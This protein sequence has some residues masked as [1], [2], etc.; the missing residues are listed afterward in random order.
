[1]KTMATSA[2]YNAVMKKKKKV[3]PGDRRPTIRKPQVAGRGG[4]FYNQ[5]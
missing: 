1:M 2:I 3:K 5:K 4:G